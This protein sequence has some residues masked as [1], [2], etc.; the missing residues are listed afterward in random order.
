MTTMKNPF[1]KLIQR[2][3]RER[4]RERKNERRPRRRWRRGRTFNCILIHVWNFI[5][6]FFVVFR[7][8]WLWPK[9][10]RGTDNVQAHAWTEMARET[11]GLTGNDRVERQQLCVYP[12]VLDIKQL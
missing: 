8:L 3:G 12:Q 1:A 6:R 11:D 5:D 10:T 2:K 4:E 9:K 7:I